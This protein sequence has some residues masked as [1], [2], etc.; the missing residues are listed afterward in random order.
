MIKNIIK[1]IDEITKYYPEYKKISL[2]NVVFDSKVRIEGTTLYTDSI[3]KA[4]LYLTCVVNNENIEIS[5]NFD[6][7]GTMIDLSRNSVIKVS[8]LKEII[9]KKALLGVNSIMLYTEDVYEVEGEPYFGYLRGRYTTEEIQEVVNYAEI[10]NIEVIPCIQTLGHMLQY[11]RWPTNNIVKDQ[12]DVLMTEIDEVYALIEKLIKTCRNMYNTKTIHVGMDETFGLALGKFYKKFGYKDPYAIFMN[13]LN[14]VNEI[15][16]RNGFETVQIWSDMFFRLLSETEEYYDKNI[17]VDK[18]IIDE[19]PDNV[20]V[21]YWDYYNSNPEIIDAMLEK[22]NEFKG[23]T[24]MAS[25]TWI[26]TRLTYD[27]VKTDAT[28]LQHVKSSIKNNVRD[29]YF[30]QWNDDGA[31]CDYETVFLGMFDMANACLANNTMSSKIYDFVA[32]QSYNDAII[33][34]EFNYSSILPITILWDDPLLGIIL[35]NEMVRNP[36]CL[37]ELR[38]YY[39][40]Y[41]GKLQNV[42]MNVFSMRHVKVLA[43]VILNKVIVRDE[44]IRRYVNKEDLNVVVDYCYDTIDSMKQLV[45]SLREMWM[46]RNKPFGFEM[47]QSRLAGGIARYEEVITRIKEYQEGKVEKI[48][49]LEEV[50][51]KFQYL[52]VKHMAIAYSTVLG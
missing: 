36:N 34:T 43:E 30:T 24:I 26:W 52:S 15:C 9:L 42:D 31:Y 50:A 41:L 21:M 46:K 39:V 17:V 3:N 38:S 4:L 2:D 28:A 48:D 23:R 19:I 51:T 35:S 44:L 1:A 49:E 7:F 37:T 33:N 8:Y 18:K 6:T 16:M 45:L 27:K 47:L 5:N 14:R 29:I 10:F 13:H 32:K 25:G 12:N 20:E 22:H 11:L 40:D